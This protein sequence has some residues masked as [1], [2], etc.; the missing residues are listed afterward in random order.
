VS[1]QRFAMALWAL[2]R[3]VPRRLFWR[4]FVFAIPDSN[5]MRVLFWVAT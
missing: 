4:A 5:Q 3:I 2:C 1:V